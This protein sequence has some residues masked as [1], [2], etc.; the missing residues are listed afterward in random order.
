MFSIVS[1]VHSKRFPEG[2]LYR[3]AT[4]IVSLPVIFSGQNCI[5]S[6]EY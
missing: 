6:N 1:F 3:T 4:E 2:L 5:H